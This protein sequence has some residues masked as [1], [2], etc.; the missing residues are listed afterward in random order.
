[1]DM[2][3]FYGTTDERDAIATLRGVVDL[4]ITLIDTTDADGPFARESSVIA[5]SASS[6]PRLML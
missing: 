6:A 1:M 3:G 2:R 5:R 4:R